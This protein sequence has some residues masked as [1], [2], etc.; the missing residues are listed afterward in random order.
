MT[1]RSSRDRDVLGGRT[2]RV[3]YETIAADR[4]R[5]R[6]LED[7]DDELGIDPAWF[8]RPA[9]GRPAEA[10]GRPTERMPAMPEPEPLPEPLPPPPIHAG[11]CDLDAYDLIE[12]E[13][14]VTAGPAAEPAGVSFDVGELLLDDDDLFAEGTGR[15]RVCR[16]GLAAVFTGARGGVGTTTLAVN[17]ATRI[18]TTGRRVCLLDLDL[19]LGAVAAALGPLEAGEGR[20]LSLDG[21]SGSL[22]PKDLRRRL[23][24]HRSGVRVLSSSGG[25]AAGW[26]EGRAARLI[27]LIGILTSAFDFVIVDAGA[28]LGGRARACLEAG[29]LVFLVTTQEAPSLRRGARLIER[30]G[31][32]GLDPGRVRVVLN[33]YHRRRGPSPD[34]VERALDLPVMATVTN[35]YRTALRSLDAGVPVADMARRRRIARDLSRLG[36]L[37]GRQPAPLSLPLTA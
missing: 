5:F 26:D 36:D 33:R 8:D 10:P 11:D 2:E 30:L 6:S 1:K 14:P 4:V 12:V 19:E 34:E 17:V 18:A 21:L 31:E 7:E 9:P 27:D 22:A 28:D 35:D 25:A 16:R 23:P 3:A 20:P 13:T 32:R 29:D 37:L 15:S 24:R